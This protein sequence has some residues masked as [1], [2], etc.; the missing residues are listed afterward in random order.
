MRTENTK[1]H[2]N[3]RICQHC[4]V[5]TSTV[6]PSFYYVS[7]ISL[8]CNINIP[9]FIGNPWWG[10]SL[11]NHLKWELV[12]MGLR[13]L[14][15]PYAKT[16]AKNIRRKE[17]DLQKRLSDLDLFTSSSSR[18]DNHPANHSEAEHNQLKQELMINHKN[19]NFLVYDWF[20]NVLFSTNSLAKLLSDSLLLDSL[21]SDSSISQSHSKM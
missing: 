21:L 10:L 6:T 2:L 18:A 5:K 4:G 13:G 9:S 19:Y 1:S 12:K 16:K 3:N 14:T 15:I 11:G 17:R 8:S 20:K 7:N